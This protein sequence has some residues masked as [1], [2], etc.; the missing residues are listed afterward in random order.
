M[1]KI[2]LYYALNKD[3]KE[4]NRVQAMALVASTRGPPIMLGRP[5]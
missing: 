5:E 4:P 2:H 1:K 3:N